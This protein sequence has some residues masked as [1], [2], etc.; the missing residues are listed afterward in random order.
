M[1]VYGPLNFVDAANYFRYRRQTDSSGC[2]LPSHPEHGRWTVLNGNGNPGGRVLIASVI[3]FECDAGYKL[4]SKIPL[5]CLGQWSSPAPECDELCPPLYPSDTYDLRCVDKVGKEVSCTEAGHGTILEYTCKT[6]YETPFGYKKT[7]FCENGK[8]DRST[9]VCQPVCGKKISNDAKPTIYGTDPNEKIEYPWIAAI[10]SKLKDSFE[11]VC[12]GSILS[13]TVVLTAAHCVTND[14]GNVLP[15][16]DYLIGVGKL[17]RSYQAPEDK[18]AQ[19]L[20]LSKIIV[21]EE[22]KADTRKFSADIA[23]LVVKKEISLTKVVQPVCFTNVKNIHLHAGSIGE[24]SGWGFTESN[25]PSEVL[26]TLVIPYKY[27]TICANELPPD[28]ADRYNSKDKI[29]AGFV[30]KSMSVC[31]GDSGGGLAFRYREDNRYYI[32]GIVSLSHQIEGMCNIQ[33]NS[34][35]TSVAYYYDFVDRLLTKYAPQ[36]KDCVLPAYPQ[37]GKWTTGKDYKPGDSVPSSTLLKFQCDEGF[38]LSSTAKVEC[39]ASY[40]MPTCEKLC[41]PLQFPRDTEFYC[42]NKVSDISDCK[43]AVEGWALS[44][45]CPSGYLETNYLR[46]INCAKGTWGRPKPECI[47]ECG[48]TVADFSGTGSEYPWNV[49]VYKLNNSTEEKYKYVCGGSLLSQYIVVTGL[50]AL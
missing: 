28:W 2:T 13:Q 9:P 45:P 8:W 26:R 7:L 19:Y 37:N 10:Y 27:E 31:T 43:K 6:S 40:K 35:Y 1:F 3:I 5:V 36:I 17:Y 47:P 41:E 20:E 38:I 24:V 22:Y 34:L 32:H 23:V 39:K 30:N 12:V 21:P 14:F 42:Y 50:V 48:R 49:G 15:T 18:N 4:S 46:V 33:Q 11:N 25:T 44:Y 16:E 29:C